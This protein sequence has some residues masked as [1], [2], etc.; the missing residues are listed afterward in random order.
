MLSG[1]IDL[2]NTQVNI[3]NGPAYASVGLG[4]IEFIAA[5]VAFVLN[6]TKPLEKSNKG[7]FI[8]Y[9]AVNDVIAVVMAFLLAI[10]LLVFA[11]VIIRWGIYGLK[12]DRRY[13]GII[14]ICQG[15]LSIIIDIISI[16]L[17]SVQTINMY[18]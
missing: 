14:G 15:G 1:V 9:A 12:A 11:V 17:I 7:F 2:E 4:T 6:I 13:L 3:Y 10:A 16:V 5:A 8:G 18:N